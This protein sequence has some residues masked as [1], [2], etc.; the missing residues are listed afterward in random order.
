MMTEKQRKILKKL[1]P[2]LIFLGIFAFLAILWL[3][4]LGVSKNYR[5]EV[6]ALPEAT[7]AGETLEF[8]V[9]VT[10]RKGNPQAGHLLA[11]ITYGAGSF[12]A[13]RVET[14][15]E[16]YATFTYYTLRESKYNP[17]EDVEIKIMDE[18]NSIFFEVNA[19]VEFTIHVIGKDA[20]GGIA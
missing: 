11:G 4:D 2:L 17:A 1:R 3:V 15:A 5:V 13:Y 9:R 12:L 8:T 18:S 7:V 20:A 10:D 6:T 19:T 16:G 14:D